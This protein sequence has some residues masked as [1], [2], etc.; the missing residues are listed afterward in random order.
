[1]HRE[2]SWGASPGKGSGRAVQPLDAGLPS[3]SLCGERAVPAF[4]LLFVYFV[5]FVVWLFRLFRL[6]CAGMTALS[7]PATRRRSQAA[8]CRRTPKSIPNPWLSLA[9][10]R[11][12]TLASL[13]LGVRP[14]VRSRSKPCNRNEPQRATEAHRGTAPNRFCKRSVS[15]SIRPDLLRVGIRGWL[16]GCSP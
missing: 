6:D 3:V 8:S 4:L 9:A 13:R 7:R 15:V 14:A 12:F 2:N 10:V 16:F 11:L 5:C 1:M